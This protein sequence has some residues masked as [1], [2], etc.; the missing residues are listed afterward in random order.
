LYWLVV[1][2][3]AVGFASS[4]RSRGVEVETERAR[5][6]ETVDVLVAVGHHSPGDPIEA[7]VRSIP[8]ALA[9]ELAI[10]ASEAAD[11]VGRSRQRIGPD[12]IITVDD[13]AAMSGPLGLAPDG[14]VVVP[15]DESTPSGV[16]IGDHVMIVSDGFLITDDAFVVGIYDDAILLAVAPTDAAAVATAGETRVTLVR[17]P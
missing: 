1:G 5:W 13:I 2:A 9:P 16:E 7:E 8:V 6:G 14:W 12:E 17:T 15:A 3:I 11:P 4:Q 10:A